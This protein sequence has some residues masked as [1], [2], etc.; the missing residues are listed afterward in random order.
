MDP[1]FHPNVF[2]VK[3]RTRGSQASICVRIFTQFTTCPVLEIDQ[4]YEMLSAQHETRPQVRIDP[5]SLCYI[6]YTSDTT[7]SP[8]G[9]AV[10]HANIVNF[11][12]S[13]TPIYGVRHNDR[14]YQG[15]PL[16]F[17]FSLEEIWSAWIAGATLVA[18]PPT[19]QHLGQGLTEFL[20][21]YCYVYIVSKNGL[22][23]MKIHL[24]IFKV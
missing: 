11:L 22:F 2:W 21:V 15:M 19:S 24:Y 12:R 20:V 1:N 6:I 4:A 14:V 9:V 10:S 7:G 3:I 17:D 13:V 23:S 18:G 5:A 8:K 16:A